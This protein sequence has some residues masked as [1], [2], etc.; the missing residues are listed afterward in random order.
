LA[1]W[2]FIL[3]NFTTAARILF[4]FPVEEDIL[5]SAVFRE[6]GEE[7]EIGGADVEGWGGGRRRQLRVVLAGIDAF[8]VTKEPSL[9]SSKMNDTSFG[10]VQLSNGFICSLG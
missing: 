3:S 6:V 5:A 10:D 8:R 2:A 7:N 4:A 1:R 9:G